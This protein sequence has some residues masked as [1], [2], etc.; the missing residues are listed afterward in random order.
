MDENI[1][2]KFTSNKEWTEEEIAENCKTIASGYIMMP[3]LDILKEEWKKA[4]TVLVS[5]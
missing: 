2:I 3:D 4:R 5:D 1:K